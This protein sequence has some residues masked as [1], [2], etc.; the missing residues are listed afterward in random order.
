MF[1]QFDPSKSSDVADALI[2]ALNA[3]RSDHAVLL[4]EAPERVS[5]AT[6][7]WVWFVTLAGVDIPAE[8]RGQQVLRIHDRG[9]SELLARQVRLSERLVGDAFPVALTS[10]SGELGGHPAHLQQRLPG[11]PAVELL[12]STKL[13]QT[14]QSLA[15]LQAQLHT[16]EPEHYELPKVDAAAYLEGDLGRR[17]S[18]ITAEDPTGTWEWLQVSLKNADQPSNEKNVLCHGDFHPLNA[19]VDDFGHIS[20]VDWTDSCIGDRHHDVA[21]TIAIYWL[22]S[23]VADTRVERAG[24]RLVRNWLGRAH[25][26]AYE[27][28]SG[29]QLDDRRLAWWQIVHLYRG[30][31]QLC[32]LAEGS[33]TDR[34]SSTTS[35]FPPDLNNRLLRR[36][37]ALRSRA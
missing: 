24:L 16:I 7:A 23:L 13:R 19:L 33:V 31:L 1:A 8:W 30:W 20:V 32:E 9:E 12:G 37:V 3:G 5:A 10:W 17:R 25:R 35:S 21:R 14:V 4:T 36:C 28:V 22:A 27:S 11:R 6:S 2:E 18:S 15:T 29:V 26:S 34:Q